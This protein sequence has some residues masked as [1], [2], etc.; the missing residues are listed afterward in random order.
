[1]PAPSLFSSAAAYSGIL[2]E[3]DLAPPGSVEGGGLEAGSKA[4]SLT[5]WRHVGKH[6]CAVAKMNRAR[7]G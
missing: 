7:A 5:R 4:A 3:V 1:M 2:L 6:N